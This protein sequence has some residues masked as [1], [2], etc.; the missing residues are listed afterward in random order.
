MSNLNANSSLPPQEEGET[1]NL[2][3]LL[4]LQSD[5]HDK[6][7]VP[8]KLGTWE[9]SAYF[10]VACPRTRKRF[11]ATTE[12]RLR[13]A[14]VSDASEMI[15]RDVITTAVEQADHAEFCAYRAHAWSAIGVTASCSKEELM[16]YVPHDIIKFAY[17]DADK[18]TPPNFTFEDRVDLRTRT[19]PGKTYSTASNNNT[20]IYPTIGRAF[21]EEE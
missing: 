1:K 13:D 15:E 2:S 20:R 3:G 16:T 8:Y 19:K 9:G 5:G 7:G 10:P 12:R 17:D 6:D 11:T 14:V 4:Y 18:Y 21:Y